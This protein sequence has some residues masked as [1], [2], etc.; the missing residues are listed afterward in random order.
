MWRGAS[1]RRKEQHIDCYVFAILGVFVCNQLDGG[2]DPR[3]PALIYSGRQIAYLLAPLHLD[4]GDYTGLA[5]N[6]VDLANLG[7]HPLGNHLPALLHQP[8]RR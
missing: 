2:S 5:R 6:E 8:L 3:K 1:A 4:E 7:L